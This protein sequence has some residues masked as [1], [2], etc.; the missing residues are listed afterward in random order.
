MNEC[1]YLLGDFTPDV[2]PRLSEFNIDLISTCGTPFGFRYPYKSFTVMRCTASDWA[3]ARYF[4][5]S[6]K[7]SVPARARG[8]AFQTFRMKC[9]YASFDPSDVVQE[10]VLRLQDAAAYGNPYA[11]ENAKFASKFISETLARLD[12]DFAIL[13][14]RLPSTW[15]NAAAAK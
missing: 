10:L 3:E 11:E 2:T 12:L 4:G 5:N 14:V 1:F 8:W 6:G 9:L 15:K 7:F 13:G